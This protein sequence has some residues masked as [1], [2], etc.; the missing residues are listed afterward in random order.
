[1]LGMRNYTKKYIDN[2]RKSIE[3][4]LSTWRRLTVAT[5]KVSAKEKALGAAMEAFE[6]SYFNKMVLVLDHFFVHRLTGVEG[7]DGNPL[8]E[9]RILSN[10]IMYNNNILSADNPYGVASQAGLTS[11]KLTAEKS[12]LK[13]E[14]GDEIKLKEADF[15]RLFKAFFAEIERKYL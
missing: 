13:Y 8:N 9:V 4:D 11:I 7:K 10:S 14:L 1:M 6:A 5:K 3:S 15:V 2:C 12:I